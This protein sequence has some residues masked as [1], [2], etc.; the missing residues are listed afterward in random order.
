MKKR[1]LFVAAIA[2][3]ATAGS[4]LPA[5]AEPQAQRDMVKIIQQSPK[6]YLDSEPG[7]SEQMTFLFGPYIIPPGQDSNRISA[8]LQLP[9]GMIRAVSPELVEAATGRVPTEQEA[10][11]H[12]A[13]WFRVTSED[14]LLYTRV[15][16]P[17]E[18]T[19]SIVNNAPPEVAALVPQEVIDSLPANTGLSWVFGTGEEKTQG[20][21][22]PREELEDLDGNGVPDVRYGLEI[23]EAE[24]QVLIYMI[25][26]KTAAP[27]EV[28][29]TLDVDF[30]YGTPE[31][32][33]QATG[34]PMRPLKGQLFGTTQ[35]ATRQNPSLI[36]K[37]TAELDSTAIV[38]G[39]HTHPGSYGVIV[40]NQ[41]PGQKCSADF[42]GDGYPGVTLFA[43]RK[44]DHVPGSWP[45]S[46]DFQMGVTKYGWRAPIR[47]GD[48]I[49]QIAPHDIDNEGKLAKRFALPGNYAYPELDANGNTV[50]DLDLDTVDGKPHQTFQ[51]MNHVGMYFD[52]AQV[53]DAYGTATDAD[54]CPLDFAAKA[55]PYLLGAD[56]PAVQQRLRVS[57]VDGLAPYYAAG[58]KEGM[59]NH[60]WPSLDPTCGSFA[61]ATRSTC[62]NGLAWPEDGSGVETDTINIA[63]FQFVPGGYGLPGEQG[64]PA[65]IKRGTPL[66]IVNEDAL[67][68]VRHTLTTC[69][70]PCT[71]TYVANFPFMDGLIDTNKLGNIDPI[72][73]SPVSPVYTL[74][75]AN[76]PVGYYSYYCRIHPFM[77]GAF[78]VV[79]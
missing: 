27:L 6:R 36:T 20:G 39:G 18:Q 71:G 25:H 57:D 69:A 70:W 46:E 32:I 41:G 65:R 14:E 68:N 72:E 34:I 58:A 1:S 51:S 75:T 33:T 37:Y 23:K 79:A 29:V 13:H 12:H 64:A 3:A 35:S 19:R 4:L 48:V 10:H 74:K 67:M 16:N 77:R 44:I 38:S 26:N 61:L 62:E 15:G 9:A 54:G 43:S 63:G 52:P 28:F 40:T 73:G 2:V 49:S 45:Y 31:Q 21:F 76:L 66:T 47:K 53:P 50:R 59:Q 7:K 22:A 17:R 56:T 55:D 78:E 8:D 24:R 30:T 11:I 5:S 42:D 60:V